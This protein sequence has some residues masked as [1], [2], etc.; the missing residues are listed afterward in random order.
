M[1]RLNTLMVARNRVTHIAPE[2]CTQLQNLTSLQLQFNRL[3]ELAQ[4]NALA[5]F[6]SLTH[7]LMQGN[8]V[9]DVEVSPTTTK[10]YR[11]E[12]RFV[13]MLT[14]VH[15]KNYRLYTIW[16]IPCI[17]YLDSDHVTDIERNAA[18]RLFGTY[19]NPTELA[20]KVKTRW[21]ELDY[22]FCMSPYED[23][24]KAPPEPLPQTRSSLYNFETNS[25]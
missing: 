2:I 8:P 10:P 1:P 4:L 13:V 16:R 24:P 3:T 6:H 21:R 23:S 22:D 19:D 9:C 25:F 18:K 15:A 14:W 5:Y 17:R 20:T 7:L 11:R 12:V